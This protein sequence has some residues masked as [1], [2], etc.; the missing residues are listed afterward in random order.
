MI[1]WRLEYARHLDAS[2]DGT[3]ARLHG[4]RWNRKG[5][6]VVYLSSQLA[7][8]AFEK[9]VHAQVSTR[10]DGLY[11]VGAEVSDAAIANAAR[12]HRLPP[13]WRSPQPDSATM[14]WGTDWCAAKQTTIALI[15]STL[16]P[17]ELFE[18]SLEFN[19]MLN[20]D[21]EGMK[22]VRIAARLPFAFDPRAWKT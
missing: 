20:P 7:L 14:Q 19:A 11:A 6:P 15:P 5:T 13:A 2:L 18:Q 10:Y 9:L 12:P 8:A 1:L 21:H 4:G 3:G 16:L 22:D 17:L